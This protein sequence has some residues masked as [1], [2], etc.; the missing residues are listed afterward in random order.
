MATVGNPG[1]PSHGGPGVSSPV[2]GNRPSAVRATSGMGNETGAKGKCRS[3]GGAGAKSR[4]SVR[5][6]LSEEQRKDIKEAFDLFDTEGTGS[7]DAKELK[8]ALRALGFEPTKEEMKKLLN[9]I[10]KKR[11]EPDV[12]KMISTSNPNAAA[13]VAA[14]A[15]VAQTATTSLGQ[16]DFNEF[17]EILTIKINEKPTREQISRGKALRGNPEGWAGFRMLA[18]PTGVIGWKEMKKAAVELG[19]KLTDEEL[20]EMLNHAS[21]SHNKGVVTE[22]DFLRILRA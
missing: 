4:R 5:V 6:E 22:E 14:S 15:P 8:V 2:G 19:E 21:H 13:A 18:G 3:H 1:S 7:I 9:E 20:R 16:L 12:M 17:L 10:E 11:R